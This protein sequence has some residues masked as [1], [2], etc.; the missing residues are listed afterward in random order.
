MTFVEQ[1]MNFVLMFS[2]L[3]WWMNIAM[4]IFNFQFL[5]LHT[6][7]HNLVCVVPEREVQQA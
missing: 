6:V 3:C 1:L 5:D 4:S 7:I 2:L